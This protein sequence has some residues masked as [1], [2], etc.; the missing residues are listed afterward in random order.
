VGTSG[1]PVGSIQCRGLLNPANNAGLADPTS[2]TYQDLKGCVPVNVFGAGNVSQSAYAWISPGVD[3]QSGFLNQVQV[4]T[5][6]TAGGASLT[7]VAP[8]QLPAGEIG[9]A[10]GVEYRL[11]QAG[12]YDA[13]PIGA[14]NI[15]QA[16]NWINYQAQYHVEEGFLEIN[17]PLLKNFVVQTLNLDLAGRITNYSSSGLVETWKIGIDSQIT[18]DFRIRGFLSSDIRAPDVYDLYNPGGANQQQCAN[19]VVGLPTNPC[20]ALPGGNPD[21]KP[22]QANTM[23][24][25]VVMTPTFLD[26]LTAS[27]DWY[28]LRMHGAITTVAY[29]TAIDRAKQ[30]DSVYCAA[31]I[32]SDGSDICN[33]SQ[34]QGTTGVPLITGVRT[35]AVNAARLTTAGFDANI[36]YRFDLWGG[37]ASV[38]VNANYVYDWSRTL[39]GVD[40]QGAGA[41]QGVYSGGA[42]FH[43]T[44]NLG[45]RTGPWTL[46]LE[47]HGT[48]DAIRDPGTEGQPTVTLAKVTYTRV[49]GQDV[50]VLG[51]GQTGQG[52]LP[53]NYAPA[54]G[55][56]GGRVQYRWSDV[57]TLYGAM[58]RIFPGNKT[59]RVGMR[60]KL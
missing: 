19:W 6:E 24:L 9:I 18:D 50:G 52:I 29:N 31:I 38:G 15:L 60:F 10:T 41:T 55:D 48:G 16:G 56:I 11:E 54:S 45:Y 32:T 58:D 36:D 22:E 33:Y 28:D 5:A 17:A 12:Q 53:T 42:S 46:G 7:G 43:T 34:T 23:E 8:W 30:G 27:L 40:F 13:T 37:E 26:G 4:R 14:R 47:I 59:Y 3:P 20:S 39:N 49:N 51:S 35:G 57:V 2:T 21:L 1:L 25:G 44:I